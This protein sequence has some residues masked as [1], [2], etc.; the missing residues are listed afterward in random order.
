VR[1]VVQVEW[2][3]G[4]RKQSSSERTTMLSRYETLVCGGGVNRL[5][6]LRLNK[7]DSCWS[8]LVTYSVN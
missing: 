6:R 4:H 7:D 3:D 8:S 1:P 5:R 2:F